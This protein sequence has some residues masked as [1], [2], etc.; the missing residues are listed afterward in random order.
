MTALAATQPVVLVAVFIGG[1]ILVVVVA[2][3][4]L[5]KLRGPMLSKDAGGANQ[6]GLFQGLR[7]MR[8]TGEISVEEYDSARKRMAARAAGKPLPP[9]TPPRDAAR[10]AKPGFDLTGAPLPESRPPDA[11]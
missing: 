11:G 9:A 10:L 1:L 3:L 8:D 4:I 5:L 6:E 2:G 7:R